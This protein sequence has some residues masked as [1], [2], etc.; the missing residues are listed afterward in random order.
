MLSSVEPFYAIQAAE[1]LLVAHYAAQTIRIMA[2]FLANLTV[3]DPA[4]G[5]RRLWVEPILLSQAGVKDLEL[6]P[7]FNPDESGGLI[8][9]SWTPGKLRAPE[10]DLRM[11][12][13][14]KCQDLLATY[15]QDDDLASKAR[16][17]LVFVR[18][19]VRDFLFSVYD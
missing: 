19:T 15:P 1:L 12:I 11:P 8:P 2:L 10:N 16:P 9:S 14:A 18:S 7:S 5:N 13:N 4:E 3:P 6:G 17:C